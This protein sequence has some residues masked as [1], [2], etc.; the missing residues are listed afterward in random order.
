MADT[1]ETPVE[2]GEGFGVVGCHP[3]EVE[4]LGVG[5]VGVGDR[6]GS[7]GPVGRFPAAKGGGVVAG[8]EIVVVG[9][10]VALFAFEFVILRV[11][12]GVVTF[13]A[14]EIK[15]GV[16]AE[17]AGDRSEDSRGAEK[18]LGV[19]GDGVA[20]DDAMGHSLAAEINVLVG[21]DA[22]SVGFV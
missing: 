4:G 5:E 17:R 1:A 9:F 16:V 22:G 7:G 15:V 18:I 11:G 19:V 14:E 21:D 10:G 2:V 12:I 20:A 13:T 6:C 8:A 3:V